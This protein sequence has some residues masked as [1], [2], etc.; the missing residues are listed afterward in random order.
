MLLVSAEAPW[1]CHSPRST[2]GLCHA[3]FL[4]CEAGTGRGH[5]ATLTLRW[6]K[7]WR[8]NRIW[9]K[10]YHRLLCLNRILVFWRDLMMTAWWCSTRRTFTHS[11]SYS[12]GFMSTEKRYL[13]HPIPIQNAWGLVF[14]Q[15]LIVTLWE[16]ISL[17]KVW[18]ENKL[19]SARL[20]FLGFQVS[21][22]T[23]WV[24]RT[25]WQCSEM[26]LTRNITRLGPGM[27]RT[28]TRSCPSSV[29]VRQWRG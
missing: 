27:T 8:Q 28:A 9:C 11:S 23:A 14:F 10:E 6:V 18:N 29:S 26:T 1:R 19:K 7:P 5:T 4:C 12:P 22:T 24:M 3:T 13:K 15:K 17:H 25:V 21:Q 20:D 2:K 16:C